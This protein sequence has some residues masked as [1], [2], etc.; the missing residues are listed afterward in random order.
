M[1]SQ[2]AKNR[3]FL[4]TDELR[5]AVTAVLTLIGERYG[6]NY[7]LS[8]SYIW[9]ILPLARRKMDMEPAPTVGNLEDDAETLRLISM[10]P[11]NITPYHLLVLSN[12]LREIG[13]QLTYPAVIND[14][15]I[16]DSG[17]NR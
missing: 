15:E 5:D 17:E 13:E 11:E 8:A 6:K 4:S 1:N 7:T 2:I 10:D 3:T 16:G 14:Q 9:G 12:L